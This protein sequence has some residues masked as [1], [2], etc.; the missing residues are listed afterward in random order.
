MTQAVL[1][2]KLIEKAKPAEP[3]KRYCL[4]DALLPQFGLRVTDRGAKS[5]VVYKRIHGKVA[6]ITLG[7]YPT[8]SLKRARALAREKLEMVEEGIDP[9][10][11]ERRRKAAE[12]KRRR[13]TFG[14]LF[15]TFAERHLSKLRT[16]DETKKI[17]EANVMPA[18]RDRPVAE[19]T[20]SDVHAILDAI[21]DRAPYVRNRTLAHLRRFLNWALERDLIDFNPAA[22]IS[23]L[24]EQRRDRVLSDAEIRLAWGAFGEMGYPFGDLF[25]L[26]LVTGQR[27]DEAAT[28]ERGEL[29]RAEGV[30]TIPPA[31]AKNGREHRVPL[32]DLALEI[33]DGLPVFRHAY[34]FTSTNGKRPVSGLSKAKAR[35]DALILKALQREAE[36]AGADPK[37]V[38]PIPQWRLHDLR[39]TAATGMAAAGVD[40]L[41]IGRVLNHADASVTGIYD[42]HTYEREKKAALN[43]WARRLRAIV[44]EPAPNVVPLRAAV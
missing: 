24:P 11:E 32:S 44:G 38:K 33:L 42:R 35:A 9:R 7:A 26:L 14:A 12:A 10:E 4:W 1:T 15:A 36:A 22:R 28:L 8:M 39:R 18:W 29:D 19:I 21:E 17:I 30:W 23:M 41:V 43:A 31:K 5:F 16:G 25:K 2:D 34:V 20:R 13:D 40:R 37:K 3:G 6:R 27:R